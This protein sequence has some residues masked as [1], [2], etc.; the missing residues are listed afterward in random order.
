MT[1]RLKTGMHAAALVVVAIVLTYPFLA[2][3]LIP[4]HDRRV[5][6]EYQHLFNEQIAEGDLYPRWM[7]GLNLGRGSPIFFVQYPLPYY[8]AWGLGRIIPNHWGD[9]TETHTQGL[10]MV[11]A[12][13]LGALFSYAWCATFADSVSAMMASVVFLTLPYFFSIDLYVRSA[14]GEV[15]ALALM[16]LAFY[17]AERRSAVPRRSLAGLAAVFALVLFSHL[18]T[19]VLL[20]PALLAYAVWRAEPAR[21]FSAMWQTAVALALGTALA[22][23]YTLPVFAHRHFLHPENVLTIFGANY[24]PLSQMFPYDLLMFPKDTPGWHFL[25]RCARLLAAATI[26]LI[27]YACYR[28]RREG[29]LNFRTFLAALSI[30][31]LGLT[32]MAGHLPGLGAVPGALPLSYYLVDQRARIFLG[33]F[34]TLEAALF[35][36]WSLRRRPERGLADFLVGMALLSFLMMTRWSLFV[37]NTLHPLWSMQFP[38]RFNVFLALATAGLAALAISNLGTRPLRERVLGG[39]LA[40]VIW[41]LVAGG[42]AE[43][44]HVSD[45]YWGTQ[46]VANKPAQDPAFPVYAQV[47]NLQEANDVTHSR[48]DQVGVVV[49]AGMGKADVSMMHPRL[50]ELHVTCESD[51]TLQ[52]GQFYYPA[53]RASLAQSGAEIP[54]RAATPGGL[55][56]ISLPTGENDVLVELPHG[57][58]EQIGPWV[59]LVSLILV[60][61]FAL[62][63]KSRRGQSATR[64]QA[65]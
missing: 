14:V 47:K 34:L 50:I 64:I 25:G 6:I 63:E 23:V 55:M 2:H 41:A 48:Q 33:S 10:G 61:V 59:S 20:A 24:S 58:S 39:V 62:S 52:I 17:F 12:A 36:Y 45:T 18:F 65:A 27:G 9:Y 13:I 49:T 19:A 54:L 22:A 40:I 56:E 44:G 46:S 53:W 51:C 8:V 21:R 38:W 57:W 43:A 1:N 5:H 26:C 31:T 16:P 3:G 28:F 32:F 15:W 29:F 4:G 37:W 30:V 35:C 42:I 60:L 11:L 7:P